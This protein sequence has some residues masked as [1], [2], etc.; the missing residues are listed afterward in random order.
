MRMVENFLDPK[1]V[2]INGT[3]Y[4][5]SRIPAIQASAIYAEV[6]KVMVDQGNLGM[7]AL[8]AN[9][10]RE[11]FKYC[12]K[13]LESGGWIVL[14]TEDSVNNAFKSLGDM[15]KLQIMMV[16]ENFGFLTDGSLTDILGLPMA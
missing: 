7:T 6:M 12:G 3:T 15:L 14:D 8:P 16:K 11:I 1:E 10:T 2:E 4:K 5:I 9:V 13:R